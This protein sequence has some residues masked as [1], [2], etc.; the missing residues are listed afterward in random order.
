MTS[1]QKEFI[2]TVGNLARYEYTER[3]GGPRPSLCIA[4]AILESGWN[5]KAKTLFGIKGNGIA[6]LTKEWNG[7]EFESIKASFKN[8]PDIA[9]AVC[10][11]YDLMTF[12]RYK[13]VVNAK[14]ISEMCIEL[15]KS[16]YA[17]DP[18]YGKTIYKLIRQFNLTSYDTM[19]NKTKYFYDY[20]F[21]LGDKVRFSTCYASSTDPTTRAISAEKMKTNVGTITRIRENSPN[22][23]LLD[24][25]LCWINKGDVREIL[26]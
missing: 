24:N 2:E 23:Y 10:G 17:T 4:Q 21:K 3:G 8:Y 7:K 13:K 14:S 25:G 9:S 12:N 22:P 26:S 11:Y 5:L 16:G 18:N 19:L 20:D 6:L 1:K 15:Q